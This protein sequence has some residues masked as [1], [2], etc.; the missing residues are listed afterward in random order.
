M[1]QFHIQTD[2]DIPASKQLFDQIHFAI[3]SRQYPPSHRLPSTRQLAA[4]TGLHRNTISKV[5]RQLEKIGLVESQAGSGIYV[6]AQRSEGLTKSSSPLLAQYPA[7]KNIITKSLD[8]I[9]AQGCNLQQARELFLSEIDWRLS[10]STKL[11]IT[12]PERDI[13]AGQLIANELEQ[14]LKISIELVSLEELPQIL[15]ES[16][17]GTVVTSKYYIKEVL[18]IATPQ[19]VR[20]IPID[21]Y[22]YR[23][24]MEMIKSL[25]HGFC[26]GIVSISSGILNVAETIVHSLRGDDLRIITAKTNDKNKLKILVRSAQTIIS[27]PASY[28]LV[29]EAI[30]AERDN[31][32]RSPQVIRSD[33]YIGSNSINL[34]QRELGLGFV[35][36][37]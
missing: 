26:L 6:K 2:S 20:V 27:D 3:A 10:C 29:K 33:N 36:L 31:L 28:S 19:A 17:S 22:D 24:E 32:I 4:L 12:V 37:D 15:E 25:P 14:S 7:A 9:L 16:N 11:L 1:V 21:I 30:L 34:L 18:E 13:G 8:E 5:Y 23:A 35:E